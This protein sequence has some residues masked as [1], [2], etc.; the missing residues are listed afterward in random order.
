MAATQA[1]HHIRGSL[2]L[3]FHILQVLA[4]RQSNRKAV[5]HK[6]LKNSTVQGQSYG[7]TGIAFNLI[8]VK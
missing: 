2:K 8:I 4:L 6:H 7:V 5:P 3:I 1:I